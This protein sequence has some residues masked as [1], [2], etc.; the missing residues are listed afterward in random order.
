MD[1]DFDVLLERYRMHLLDQ[2]GLSGETY[3]AYINDLE[4]MIVFMRER[5]ALDKRAVRAYMLHM[6]NQFARASI[7]RKLSA[8][9]GFFDYALREGVLEV[10][11][12][13]H[14]RS[15]K[16]AEE[17]PRFM[18]PE[19]VIDLIEATD[20]LRDQAILEL[21]YSTGIRVG[22]IEG[23]QCADVDPV[24]G[25][26]R[27]LGKGSK[28][29]MVP[30]GAHALAAIAAYLR[31]RGITDPIYVR[32]PLFLNK[33]GTRLSA[34]SI[35]RIIARWSQEVAIARR[36][37][38]HV[39]RHSF[40]THLLDAG[41]DLR[42]IQEMLGHASLSTTQRYTHLTVDKLMEVYDQAHP[43]AREK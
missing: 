23:M 25:F 19:E 37:S 43:R 22:E 3:R 28:Q 18:T 16:K 29:R 5:G 11:P 14:V 35:R 4:D 12:F 13:A 40:A 9:K 34:R 7:N 26:I 32:E 36:V 24:S 27:V 39:I 1:L 31:Q 21:L 30:V 33:N 42:S 2:K 41:A 8:I 20:K 17:L 15:L 6:H 38:P 10:N